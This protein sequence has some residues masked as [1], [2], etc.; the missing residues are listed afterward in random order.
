MKHLKGLEEDACQLSCVLS[1][2]IELLCM[3]AGLEAPQKELIL[4]TLSPVIYHDMDQVFL[5]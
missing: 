3:Q 5:H 4:A 2:L 1:L